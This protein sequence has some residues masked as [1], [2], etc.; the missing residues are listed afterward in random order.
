MTKKRKT[1]Y[2]LLHYGI[3]AV[4]IM[5]LIS[6]VCILQAI[7]INNKLAV[8]LIL[9]H[10]NEIY[11]YI[12][13]GDEQI[14]GSQEIMINMSDNRK[15]PLEIK[16]INVEHSFFVCH[17]KIKTDNEKERLFSHDRK[18]I[19]YIITKRTKLWN[20]ILNRKTRIE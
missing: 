6:I 3:S 7:E 2:F 13:K 14:L 11:C 20:L 16:N 5:M 8:E 18:I 9:E 15:I 17:V 19:A 12:P 10:D 4:L 1:Y